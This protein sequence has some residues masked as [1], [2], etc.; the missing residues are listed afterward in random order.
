MK[1]YFFLIVMLLIANFSSFGDEPMTGRFVGDET[2]GY[3]QFVS[4]NMAIFCVSKNG[5]SESLVPYR[6]EKNG[7]MNYLRW[8]PGYKYSYLVLYSP[9]ICFFFD[10]D[11][12][13]SFIGIQ[14][15][16]KDHPI[17]SRISV[18][19]NSLLDT[20]ASYHATSELT[21]GNTFYG[22]SNL[23]KLIP[24]Y[25]W[26]EGDPGQG[27]GVSIDI[28]WR[29]PVLG[30]LISNGYVSLQKPYLFVMNSRVKRIRIKSDNFDFTTNLED[31]PN[32]QSIKLPQA[33]QSIT[34]EIVDV[35][36]G[37]KWSDTCINFIMGICS[38]L[39]SFFFEKRHDP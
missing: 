12:N 6:I 19:E 15:S 38:P 16:D 34:L 28:K 25:P 9:K 4:S 39:D 27:I 36:P 18:S 35:F 2:D 37:S 1:K 11:G 13:N 10:V 8:G 29:Q 3:I 14:Y 31:S 24:G 21:E 32:P 26:V 33:A 20:A 7:A 30:I 22:A 23:G 5:F 17:V